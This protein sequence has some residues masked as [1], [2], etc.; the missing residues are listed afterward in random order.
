MEAGMGTCDGTKRGSSYT[1]VSVQALEKAPTKAMQTYRTV[2]SS[3]L[4]ATALDNIVDTDLSAGENVSLASTGASD[5]SVASVTV[6]HV[7]S[8]VSVEVG[9]A[10]MGA[11]SAPFNVWS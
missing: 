2:E 9:K 7:L 3:P 11:A 10:A 5:R 6:A 8:Q 1:R 4:P